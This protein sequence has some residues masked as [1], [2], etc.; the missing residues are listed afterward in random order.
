MQIDSRKTHDCKSM[1]LRSLLK[2]V[3]QA[4]QASMICLSLSLALVASVLRQRLSRF[5]RPGRLGEPG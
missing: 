4:R 1:K 2:P 3:I 5:A